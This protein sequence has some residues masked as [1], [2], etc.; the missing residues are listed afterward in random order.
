MRHFKTQIIILALSA[1]FLSACTSAVMVGDR[2]VGV[3]SGKFFYTDG[4]LK[5]DYG[6]PFEIAWNASEKALLGM[7]ATILD[8]EKKISSGTDNAHMEGE[9]VRVVI[10]YIE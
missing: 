8:K 7:N 9:D 1:F 3:R 5:T 2:V 10:E 4:T 6:V